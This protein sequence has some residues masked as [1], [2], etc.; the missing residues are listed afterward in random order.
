MG[1]V[2]TVPEREIAI[3]AEYTVTHRETVLLEEQFDVLV[4]LATVS[5]SAAVD[6]IEC[7]K[8]NVGDIT[9][10]TR[11]FQRAV[12]V[13]QQDLHTKFSPRFCR[14]LRPSLG[15][16]HGIG[17]ITSRGHALLATVASAVYCHTVDPEGFDVLAK[18]AL[19]TDLG[20]AV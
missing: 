15:F 13:V 4:A 1:T 16:T 6:V 9:S 5:T 17:G 2:A 3:H 7:Q 14:P 12:G 18:P 19:V 20:L 11:A 8:L 10:R